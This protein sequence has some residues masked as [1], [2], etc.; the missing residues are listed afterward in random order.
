V[1]LFGDRLEKF[2]GEVQALLA[3]RSAEG[4]FWDWPADTEVVMAWR[5]G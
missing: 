5:P 3:D 1:H 2:A 4:L